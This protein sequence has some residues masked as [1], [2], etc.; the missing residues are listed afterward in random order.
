MRDPRRS[1]VTAASFE[2]MMRLPLLCAGCRSGW[3]VIPA[4]RGGLA[5]RVR[6]TPCLN[7]VAFSLT[8]SVMPRHLSGTA[9]EICEQPA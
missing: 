1:I 9:K 6:A 2:Q 5:Q 8:A 3:S 7:R 4:R